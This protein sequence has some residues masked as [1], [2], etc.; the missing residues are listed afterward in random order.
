MGPGQLR[1]EDIDWNPNDPNVLQMALPGP[2]CTLLLADGPV[3]LTHL[4]LAS[5]TC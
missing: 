5:C 4:V 2:P 1:K 3:I